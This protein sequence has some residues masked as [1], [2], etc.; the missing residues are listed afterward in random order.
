MRKFL[1]LFFLITLLDAGADDIFS[2]PLTEKDTKIIDGIFEDI[3]S[4]NFVRSF[5]TQE[6]L[7]KRLNRTL[8]STGQMLFD[9]RKGIAWIVKKPFPS[10][11]VLTDDAMIQSGSGGQERILS[12]DGN[13]SFQRF[14]RT[15]QSIFLGRLDIISI[16][17]EIFFNQSEGDPWHIGLIPVDSTLKEIVSSFELEGSSYIDSF[18]IHEAG[19]DT[20]TYHFSNK[21]FPSALEPE[22]S[23]VFP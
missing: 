11:T 7:V 3:S 8:T 4:H 5:F 13:E 21:E 6:K 15:V 2:L 16:E 22:E 14:S 1:L 23:R 18:I 19:G 20:I 10:T 17:Y 12:A 9:S